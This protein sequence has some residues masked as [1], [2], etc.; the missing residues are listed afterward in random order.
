MRHLIFA[1]ICS[2]FSQYAQA[3][4]PDITGLWKGTMYNDSTQLY[5]QYEV[6]ISQEK[7]KL[8][9]YSHTWFI[10]GDKQ[11]YG[12]K[13]ITVKKKNGQILIEDN[14][15]IANNYPVSP[16]KNIRQFN[17]LTLEIKDSLMIMK[18][19]FTT[20][21]TTHYAPLTE[22]I[23]LKR[24]YDFWQSALIPHLKELK[25][26]K[27]LSFIQDNPE[28]ETVISLVRKQQ[29]VHP[30]LSDISRSA[31]I[32]TNTKNV[33]LEPIQPT[34][35]KPAADVGARKTVVQETVYFS[36]DSI[37]ISLFDNG[38]VDGDTVSVLMNGE[39]FLPNKRLG[40]AAV[41]KNIIIDRSVQEIQLVMYAENLGSIPPNTGLMVV[42][43]GKDM[44]EIRFSGD[45]QKNAAIVLK[46]K[47]K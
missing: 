11:Y 9:G 29:D 22:R 21:R 36:S 28:P 19:P 1:F 31:Q 2:I 5:Y 40:V 15:L 24:K 33:V 43:D 34:E 44:Y 37:Q 35:K 39:M 12:V 45:L 14:G 25:K 38:E 20:N 23:I 42:K 4:E 46:R 41:K 8:S 18:G 32:V 10:L 3:Q 27:K 30:K 16:A 6:A 17:V 47:L 13:K 7:G 26:E